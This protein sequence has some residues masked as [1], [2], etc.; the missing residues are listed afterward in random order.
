MSADREAA[1]STAALATT[2]HQASNENRA[3]AEQALSDGVVEAGPLP[4]IQP[5]SPGSARYRWEIAAGA[6]MRSGVYPPDPP[7]PRAWVEIVRAMLRDGH[8]DAAKQA[9]A[10]LRSQHPD[11]RIPADL[12]G[13]E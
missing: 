11:Y 3:Q 2:P 7:P 6:A 12:R 8:R 4:T 5:D 1:T 10:E 9:L 13:L